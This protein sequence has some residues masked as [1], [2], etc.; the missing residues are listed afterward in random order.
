MSPLIEESVGIGMTAKA[1]SPLYE[2]VIAAAEAEAHLGQVISELAERL[3]GVLRPD[4]RCVPSEG[5]I[6]S[7]NSAP[8]VT[9]IQHHTGAI[10][11][12]TNR[13]REILDRLDV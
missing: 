1:A 6:V 3:S 10:R 7:E 2:A 11:S 5:Y 8:Y 12:Q 9:Q 4:D 13:L